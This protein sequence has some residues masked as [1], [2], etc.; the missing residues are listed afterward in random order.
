[1]AAS[2]QTL[3]LEWFMIEQFSC[4]RHSERNRGQALLGEMIKC[5]RVECND[6]GGEWPML[7]TW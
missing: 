5:L 7:A 6:E 2:R 4:A 1:M 3:G